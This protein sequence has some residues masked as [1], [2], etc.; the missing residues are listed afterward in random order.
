MKQETAGGG[1]RLKYKE[2]EQTN[3]TCVVKKAATSTYT[4]ASTKSA[5]KP[6]IPKQLQR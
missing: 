5:R 2:N 6:E 1:S 3:H 4:S